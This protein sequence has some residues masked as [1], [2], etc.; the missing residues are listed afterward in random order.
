MEES[1][2]PGMKEDS[3]EKGRLL[4]VSTVEGIAVNGVPDMTQ[5]D[6]D[7]VGSSCSYPAFKERKTGLLPEDPVFSEG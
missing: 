2:F 7:L 5:M 4:L 1:E 3:A 6:P